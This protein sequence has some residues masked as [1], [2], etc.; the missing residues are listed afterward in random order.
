MRTRIGISLIRSGDPIWAKAGMTEG[1]PIVKATD[2]VTVVEGCDAVRIFLE[3]VLR[4]QGKTDE[5]IEFVV[6]GSK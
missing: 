2:T 1:M 6:G 5:E 3:I 4:R